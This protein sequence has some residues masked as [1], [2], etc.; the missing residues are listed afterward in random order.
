MKDAV[1]I[2]VHSERILKKEGALFLNYARTQFIMNLLCNYE[3]KQL[4]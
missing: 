2:L 3:M 4:K 1:Y